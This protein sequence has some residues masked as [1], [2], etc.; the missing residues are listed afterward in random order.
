MAPVSDLG[1]VAALGVRARAAEALPQR[2]PEVVSEEQEVVRQ[3]R[4]NREPGGKI[5]RREAPRVAQPGDQREPSYLDRQHQEDVHRERRIELREGEEDRAA[6]EEIRR[7]RIRGQ[8]RRADHQQVAHEEKQVVTHRS[9]LLLQRG[10]AQVQ[11]VEGEGHEHPVR[12]RRIGHEGEEAPPLPRHHRRRD[13]HHPRRVKQ[14]KQGRQIHKCL[15]H[16][17]IQG[18]VREGHGAQPAFQP[19]QPR[20][21]GGNVPRPRP[22][23]YP[24]SIFRLTGAQSRLLLSRCL[25]NCTRCRAGRSGCP[26][27][28]RRGRGRQRRVLPDLPRGQSRE[29][30]ALRRGPDAR[31]QAR[32]EGPDHAATDFGAALARRFV[33]RAGRGGRYAGPPTRA[34]RCPRRPTPGPRAPA[35]RIPAARR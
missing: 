23:C 14:P 19:M 12:R 33:T 27:G 1:A 22:G 31:V 8:E 30:P 4:R 2:E 11:E 9:P 24:K 6:D 15:S 3:R 21:A 20:H 5:P 17:Q 28:G 34:P 25:P 32:T 18:E 10:S 16:H 7:G 13:Q 35:R 26:A 29:L